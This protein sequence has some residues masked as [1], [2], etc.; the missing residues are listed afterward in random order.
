MLDETVNM[1]DDEI[2]KEI[3]AIAKEYNVTLTDKQLSKLIELCRSLEGLDDSQLAKRVEEVQSTLKK[4]SNAK[5]K[6][7]GF[8][9]TVKK[10]V[11]SIQSFFEKIKD[12]L[13]L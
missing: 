2:K 6:V 11:T 1:S 4:V 9:T 13:H 10:V 3:V 7:S 8:V 5:A 12:I